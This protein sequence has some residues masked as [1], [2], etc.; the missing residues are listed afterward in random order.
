M[1]LANLDRDQH[2]GSDISIRLASFTRFRGPAARQKLIFFYYIAHR[3]HLMLYNVYGIC[4]MT[5]PGT[6][7]RLPEG[8]VTFLFTDIEGS[9]RLWER[10][11][12]QMQHALA[13]HDLLLQEAIALNDG[14]IVKSTGDGL[15]A[16]FASPHNAVAAALAAQRGLN[17]EEWP[18]S[19]GPLRARMA[20]H[21]AAAEL[22]E[23]DYFGSAVNRAA[24][25]MA[26]GHGG[27]I[28]LSQ[29]TVQLIRDD[30][31][32]DI[33]LLELGHFQ[34]KDLS[35]PERIFQILTSDLPD[36][37]PELRTTRVK[38][39]NLPGQP[40]QFI[41]RKA[42]LT[43]IKQL[44]LRN[45][46]RLVT[47]TGPGGIGKTRLGLQVATDLVDDPQ[48]PFPDGVFFV[49]LVPLADPNLI[50]STMATV[51]NVGESA[52]RTL[53]DSLKEYLRGKTILIV[54]DNME[55]L[56]DGVDLLGEL[57][58]AAPGLMLLATSREALNILEEWLFPLDGLPYPSG[59][60]AEDIAN[61]GA[62]QLFTTTAK[63]VRPDFKLSDDLAGVVRICQLVEGMPLAIELAAVWTKS[64]ATSVI[65]A[66]IERNIDFLESRMRNLPARHRSMRAA[67]D[68]SWRLL[69]DNERQVFGRLSVF[70]GGFDREAAQAVAD[71]SLTVLTGLGDRSLLRWD[72][73][74]GRYHSHELLRQFGAGQLDNDP[75]LC[76][77][78][79]N[80]HCDYFAEFCWNNAAASYGG[81]SQQA[82]EAIIAESENVQAAWRWAVA[83][84]KAREIIR[85]IPGLSILFT[86]KNHYFRA[87]DEFNEGLR[88]M[89]AGE[90]DQDLEL[91]IATTQ[92]ELA[93]MYIRLG[94]LNEAEARLQDS[95][96]IYE[97]LNIP[98]AM[99]GQAT[100]PNL[101]LGI[102]A[103][104][105]G[106]FPLVE[107]YGLK[108]LQT[109]EENEHRL[110]IEFSF[111]LLARA[112]IAQGHYDL[113]L[114][115]AT[116]MA[117]LIRENKD[118]WLMAYCLIE[119]GNAH[120]GLGNEQEALEQYEK[121][122]AIRERFKDPEGMAVALNNIA[123]VALRRAELEK[124]QSI[125]SRSL[126]IYQEIGDRGGLATATNG[127]AK[128]TVA[129]GH[130]RAAQHYFQQALPVAA[131]INFVPLVMTILTGMGELLLK[132]DQTAEGQRLLKYV[133]EHP[134]AEYEAHYL[135]QQILA[136]EGLLIEAGLESDLAQPKPELDQVVRDILAK[137]SQLQL[138]DKEV[139]VAAGAQMAEAHASP[140]HPELVESLTIRELE[141]LGHIAGGLTNKQIAELLIISPGTVKWYTSQ[142]YGK[143]NT[144]NRTQAVS[145]ARELN[146]LV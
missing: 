44:V 107:Q 86:N 57:L 54:L 10:H 9:T 127:L 40:T 46:V 72:V 90:P 3:I 133:T 75:N 106:D 4:E 60:P 114:E 64:L 65:A 122:F 13:R 47:I 11:S 134:G 18:Q 138:S 85:C 21:T 125:Y 115:R 104:I 131:D 12:D 146:L 83:H 1:L 71:A 110:N 25:L 113:A 140:A 17:G 95:L 33:T 121:A 105:R 32:G 119:V 73:D 70:R 76:D 69:T 29:A 42:E 14:I 139:E 19:I 101:G 31:P 89:A 39:S 112:A 74:S 66:E 88:F 144:S 82:F 80:K 45:E 93:W 58:E 22:R 99:P 117:D 123:R 103:S 111:Y 92:V 23:G 59:L 143:L 2:L 52:N 28:L 61:F 142:I 132:V 68:Y 7:N 96:K 100:D 91:A 53:V 137:F 87:I 124:A 50:A 15:Q 135:A 94:R 37:F 129:Q 6:T 56:L 36:T 116:K 102:I 78:V 120:L 30:L 8:A 43:G 20:L 128:V 62:V 84:Q 49:D 16:A 24:R 79:H 55:H 118:E 77:T 141:I 41:G 97:K 27:Q 38:M 5:N 26:A 35:R 51:L 109:S 126:M 81:Q 34:L 130:Y 108:A 63:R 67:F 136:G 98:R 48:R 145:R